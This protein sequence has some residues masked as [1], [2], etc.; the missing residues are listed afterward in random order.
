MVKK[1]REEQE[2][3]KMDHMQE[4]SRLKEEIENRFKIQL[5]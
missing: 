3:I 5:D 4:M 1:M 2:K